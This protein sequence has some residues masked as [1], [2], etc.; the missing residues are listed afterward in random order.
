MRK[1]GVAAAALVLLVLSTPSSILAQSPGRQSAETTRSQVLTGKMTVFNYLLG[2]PWAC[3]PKPDSTTLQPAPD[4]ALTVTPDLALT[5][6]FDVVSTNVLHLHATSSQSFSDS[7][8]GF[9]S[10]NNVYYR[11][12]AG[13]YGGAMRETSRDGENFTGTSIT[14]AGMIATA[15]DTF[16]GDGASRTVVSVVSFNGN[17]QTL[18][19]VCTR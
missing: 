4:L 5:V 10:K 9:D 3:R 19:L 7:Y 15:R 6:T 8:F 1:A 14:S 11:S 16:K 18:I 2:R 17:D 13:S 12:E